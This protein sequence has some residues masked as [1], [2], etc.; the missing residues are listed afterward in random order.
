MKSVLSWQ[1]TW[2]CRNLF[3]SDCINM[4]ITQCPFFAWQ[5]NWLTFIFV[6]CNGCTRSPSYFV[7]LLQ[8]V[9][10]YDRPL[11]LPLGMILWDHHSFCLF[12]NAR[13]HNPPK[14]QFTVHKQLDCSTTIYNLRPLFRN[15]RPC[16]WLFSLWHLSDSTAHCCL[17]ILWFSSLPN[18]LFLFSF[19]SLAELIWVLLWCVRATD[20]SYIDICYSERCW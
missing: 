13:P 15:L 9:A 18:C 19:L 1:L 6:F 16:M 14:K 2:E 4:K 3:Q 11:C 5:D 7:F 17:N 20:C 8:I 10:L 12:C